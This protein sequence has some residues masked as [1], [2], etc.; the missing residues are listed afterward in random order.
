MI[1]LTDK[2]LYMLSRMVISLVVLCSIFLLVFVLSPL[3]ETYTSCK[4]GSCPC[5]ST[6]VVLKHF[7]SCTLWTTDFDVQDMWGEMWQKDLCGKYSLWE[8]SD[9]LNSLN[10]FVNLVVI[11]EDTVSVACKSDLLQIR[12]AHLQSPSIFGNMS[13]RPKISLAYHWEYVY[14]RLRTP[15]LHKPLIHWQFWEV[16]SFQCA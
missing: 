9:D 15:I 12:F 13:C 6:S 10:F 5:S 3:C 4:F 1:E 16:L 2:P 7:I 8:V 14:P 11:V